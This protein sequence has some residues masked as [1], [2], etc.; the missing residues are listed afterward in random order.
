MGEEVTCPS[1]CGNSGWTNDDIS[2]LSPFLCLLFGKGKE[3]GKR[4]QVT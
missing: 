4:Y 1:G 2:F 3:R